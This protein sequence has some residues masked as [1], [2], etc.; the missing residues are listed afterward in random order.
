MDTHEDFPLNKRRVK[1]TMP[2]PGGR[3]GLSQRTADA[4]STGQPDSDNLAGLF[5]SITESP[6]F[7]WIQNYLMVT[8]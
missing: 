2:L 8:W 3:N 7:G 4:I 6:S 1:S 5:S